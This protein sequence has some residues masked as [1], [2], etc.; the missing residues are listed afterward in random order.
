MHT[1]F[2]DYAIVYTFSRKVTWTLSPFQLL[3]YKSSICIL[4]LHI[5]DVLG[6]KYWSI[7]T[8]RLSFC[9]YILYWWP[10]GDVNS[11]GCYGGG[12]RSSPPELL[13]DKGV[14]KLCNMFTG[15]HPRWSVISIKL[16]SNFAEIKLRHGCYPVNFLQIFR[17]TFPKNN[18]GGLL[19]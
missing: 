16:Q 7:I 14:L 12:R 1:F 6:A 8:N 17:K 3:L 10:V 18:F 19:L 11:I 2:D 5:V 13:L 15:E 4:Y 9:K